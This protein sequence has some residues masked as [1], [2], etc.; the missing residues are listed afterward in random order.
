MLCKDLHKIQDMKAN[1]GL[2]L[3]IAQGTRRPYSGGLSTGLLG[4][5]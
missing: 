2:K 3:P 5:G 1:T 4:L